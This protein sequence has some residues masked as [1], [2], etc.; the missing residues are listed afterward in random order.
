MKN[1][2]DWDTMGT[3]LID[4]LRNVSENAV[5]LLVVCRAHD[6]PKRKFLKK[7]GLSVASEWYVG[8]N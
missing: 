8:A 1:S 6:E 2:D 4:T 5:Q 3:K 7:I